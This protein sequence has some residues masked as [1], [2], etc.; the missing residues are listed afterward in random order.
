MSSLS[1][2]IKRKE[3]GIVLYGMTPPKENTDLLKVKEI[4]RKHLNRIK[5][6][7][8]DGVVLYDIQD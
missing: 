1:D 7:D 3:A 6:L 4:A 2:K 8:I 5:N